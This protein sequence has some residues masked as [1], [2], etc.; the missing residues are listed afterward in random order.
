MS[1]APTSTCD[2]W[3]PR[4]RKD[5]IFWPYES[6]GW[7]PIGV[8]LA[9]GATYA[10]GTVA[11]HYLA[12]VLGHIPSDLSEYLNPSIL[13]N[14]GLLAYL[15]TAY[16]ALC[17]G[18]EQDL[19][20][21]RPVLR[22]GEPEFQRLVEE[23]SSQPPRSRAVA[24]I[25]GAAIG[26]CVAVFDPQI[27][28]LHEDLSALDPRYLWFLFQNIAVVGLGTRL[29]AVDVYISRAYA[30]IG[31]ELVRVDLLDP[32]PLSP[33]VRKGQRSAVIWVVLSMLVSM[34]WVADS[35]ALINVVVPFV[36]LI[37]V[38]V[39]FVSPAAGV[40]RS[41]RAAKDAELDRVHEEIRGL[42]H[43]HLAPEPGETAD[44]RLGNLI[45]YRALIAAV[46]DWPFDAPA[47]LRFALIAALGVFSWLGGAVV[48]RLLAVLLD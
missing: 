6:T 47:L 36:L 48:E 28:T 16:V 4:S 2:E 5:F 44:A 38:S 27:K 43:A 29:G 18:A 15:P 14:A 33:F 24:T 10:L 39:A 45:A 1:E 25:V 8:G 11:T 32:K 23:A 31:R 26:F 3:A 41:I 17:R 13:I 22:C 46:H 12:G 42:R 40:R 37:L 9:I 19:R 7:P 35:A 21:L 30:R 20:D 34:Y